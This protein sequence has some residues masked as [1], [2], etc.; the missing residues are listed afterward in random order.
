[1][2]L[3][4]TR[5][6]DSAARALILLVRAERR[7]KA[8][9]LAEQ[10]GTTAG[11]MPQIIG[12]LVSRGWVRSEPGPTG[13]YLATVSLDTVS[14]LDVIESVDGPTDSGRCVVAD[15]WCDGRDACTLHEAWAR[16]RESLLDD[17]RSTRLAAFADRV[18]LLR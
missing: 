18:E 7:M 5:R 13:G 10:L 9:E 8:A 6:A 4:V 2:R 14:V 3:D 12:P 17:L 1:M 15:R 16:A 11:F